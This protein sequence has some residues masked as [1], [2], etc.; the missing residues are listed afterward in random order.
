MHRSRIIGKNKI[1]KIPNPALGKRGEPVKVHELG[2]YLKKKKK[3][4]IQGKR[5][6]C[7]QFS[8][9]TIDHRVPGPELTVKPVGTMVQDSGKKRGKSYIKKKRQYIKEKGRFTY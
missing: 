1:P 8:T 6:Q 3:T 2:P 7:T 9:C 5:Y 4:Y